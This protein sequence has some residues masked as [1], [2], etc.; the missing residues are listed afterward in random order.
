MARTWL[1]TGCSEGGIGAAIARTVLEA[2]DHVAVTA[3]NKEKV[4]NIVKDFPD[5]AF[6]V[7][8]DVT[9]ETS[10]E[11]AVSQTVD[12]FGTIDILVN[13]AGYCYRA[14]VE[15]SEEEEVR[16]MFDTNFFGLVNLT[17]KVLPIMR[18]K[19]SGMII[20]FSSAAALHGSPASSFYAA[21][22]AAVEIMSSGLQAEVE[23]LGIKVMVVEPG[24][25]RT[26]F[27]GSSLKGA[28]MT[29]A[30]YKDTAWPRYPE[31]AVNKA[32]QPGDP[33]KAGKVLLKAVNSEN[34]PFRLLLGKMVVEFA[35]K[36]YD[37]RIKELNQWKDV[38]VTA[39]FDE[40]AA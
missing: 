12:H 27:F 31:N 26:N 40:K 38:S 37:D 5:H 13:N 7:A 15:E 11:Q 1:I 32:D 9:D 29:I 39:D 17:K 21:T 36:E 24:P 19:R 23:P 16:K 3:R 28:P 20:N 6:A 10:I 8:L 35:L 14:S 2:G 33:A 4:K 25:F 22:K 18:M 30:D 34:P